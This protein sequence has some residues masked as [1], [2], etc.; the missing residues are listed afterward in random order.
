MADLAGIS[1][2]FF[3]N[4]AAN[5]LGLPCF[6]EKACSAAVPDPGPCLA[7]AQAN[8]RHEKCGLD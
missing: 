8:Y 2:V 3:Q 5:F 6:G 1:T 7:Q 4:K